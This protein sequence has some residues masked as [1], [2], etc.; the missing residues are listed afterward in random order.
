MPTNCDWCSKQLTKSRRIRV[1]KKLGWQSELSKVRDWLRGNEMICRA[2]YKKTPDINLLPSVPTHIPGNRLGLPNVPKGPLGY[3]STCTP[4]AT[5]LIRMKKG[6]GH[7]GSNMSQACS[8][9]ESCQNCIALQGSCTTQVCKEM[10]RVLKLLR[11][12]KT[13]CIIK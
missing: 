8:E 5:A 7:L 11:K 9:I 10:K 12:W 2:C 6:P 3:R 13:D 4:C 1:S